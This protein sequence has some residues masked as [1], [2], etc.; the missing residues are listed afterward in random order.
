MLHVLAPAKKG[1]LWLSKLG[2]QS[3]Q[4]PPL[5]LTAWRPVRCCVTVRPS[6]EAPPIKHLQTST[7]AHPPPS[8]TPTVWAPP[9][10]GH[11]TPD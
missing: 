11:H 7:P 10:L 3:C 9:P 1:C 4:A 8:P 6:P 2:K 5:Q